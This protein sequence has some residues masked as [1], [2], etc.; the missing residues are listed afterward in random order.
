MQDGT[1]DRDEFY[2]LAACL[3]KN[4]GARVVTQVRSYVKQ[5]LCC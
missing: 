1:L 4:I 3:L 5:T 2:L